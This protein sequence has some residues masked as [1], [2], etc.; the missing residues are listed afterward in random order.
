M[1]E[2]L[3]SEVEDFNCRK[4]DSTFIYQSGLDSHIRSSHSGPFVCHLCM[5]SFYDHIQLENHIESIHEERNTTDESILEKNK[6]TNDETNNDE[7]EKSLAE[8]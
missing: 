4:C 5:Y 6:T 8:N 7:I 1:G 3:L 2:K